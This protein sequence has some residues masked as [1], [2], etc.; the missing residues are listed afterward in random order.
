MEEKELLEQ[1]N[2]PKL[3]ETAAAFWRFLKSPRCLSDTPTPS[4]QVWLP[5]LQLFAMNTA[6]AF[7]AALLVFGLMTVLG[8][9]PLAGHK[10][11]SF[12][13][14][15]HFVLAFLLVAVVGPVV[16]EF[17]FR[18]PLRF[19]KA[20]AFTAFLG[21]CLFCLPL[22]L[23]VLGTSSLINIVLVT[24]LMLLTIAFLLSD[25]WSERLR[26]VWQ[27]HFGVVFYT[28]SL[29][30]ALMHLANFENLDVPLALMPL[31][32]VPQ[33]IGGLFWGYIRLRY[34]LTWAILGHGLFNAIAIALSYITM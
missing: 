3:E 19:T 4:A 10:L 1:A 24:L 33:F 31:L 32:V 26:Q 29:L 23:E 27:R 7:G 8:M 5:F 2:Q 14:D 6:T 18:L 11:E 13:L 34:S 25:T 22:A 9:D 28:F 17:F 16:E 15:T 30:F 12:L 20:R 21:I